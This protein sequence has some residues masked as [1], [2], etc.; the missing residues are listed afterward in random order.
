VDNLTRGASCGSP[1]NPAL[2]INTAS[3]KTFRLSG[4]TFQFTGSQTCGG[5]IR[6]GGTGQQT[7]VDHNHFVQQFSTGI[8]WSG[9]TFGVVD[10]NFFEAPGGVWNAVKFQEGN[11]GNNDSLGVGDQSWAA[12]TNFGS[13]QFVFVENNEF[14]SN[15]TGAVSY[16]NDCTSGGRYVWR[17][18]FMNNINIQTHPTGGGQ[19]HRGC[20]AT[21]VYKNSDTGTGGVGA[22]F[23]F[24]WLSSGPSLIWGNTVDNTFHFFVT[25]HSMRRDN[26]T[27]SQSPSP[28][29]W[30]YCGTSFN[31]IGSNWD[32]NSNTS[33]GY[34]CLDQPGQGQSDLLVNDFPNAVNLST[35]TIAWPHQA[36][37]PV[38]EWLNNSSAVTYWNAPADAE[39]A[40]AD[41]YLYAGSFTGATGTGSGLLSARPST[42]TPRVA[43]WATNTQ[44]LFQCATTN[45]W[46]TYYTPYTYPHPLTQSSGTPPAA[47]SNLAAVVQ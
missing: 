16:A 42:C 46:T 40:N 18:N 36:L 13:S 6:I 32:Q 4:I 38:Y 12:A 30:G 10:H 5:S 23:N 34:R 8:G 14:H 27:Y 21:E 17:Y 35:G 43:Y 11:W 7:R 1:D 41:Y 31:G 39:I 29:G 3:N 37:E 19:R 28:I 33:A 24:F 45:T 15:F 25:V 47:P 20:R 22:N 2:Q 26:S 44:T 9:W